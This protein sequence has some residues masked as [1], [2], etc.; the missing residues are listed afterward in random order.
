[1]PARSVVFHSLR[2]FDGVKFDY[3]TTRDYLQM[4]GRAG[5]QGIDEEGL[6][7]S[8]LSTKDLLE[9]PLKRLQLGR[10]EPV[11]SRSRRMAE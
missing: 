11:E 5:R 8:L 9:A 6:V 2:K 4:A 7:Y 1:M 3:M 10:P